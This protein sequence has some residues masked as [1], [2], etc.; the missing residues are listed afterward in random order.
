[1]AL[2]D[3]RQPTAEVAGETVAL[4]VPHSHGAYWT[5]TRLS[6]E[7]ADRL[8]EAMQ[9]SPAHIITMRS[10]TE[11][12]AIETSEPVLK[13]RRRERERRL[14]RQLAATTE[15]LDASRR[16]IQDLELALANERHER[17][18]LKSIALDQA[19][20]LAQVEERWVIAEDATN[21]KIEGNH[22]S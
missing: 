1:M 20:T 2:P 3:T 19:A 6:P 5:I 18:R 11:Y 8:I 16:R 17:K 15:R 14:S 9:N 21:A 4:L 7:D 22:S 12:M 10:K 13:D